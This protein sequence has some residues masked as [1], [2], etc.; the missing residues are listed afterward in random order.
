VLEVDAR[1]K[2]ISLGLK[3]LEPDPGCSS[4][5]KYHPGDK[6]AGKVRSLTDYGVFVGNRGG[7]R[8]HGCTRAISRG[9][10]ASTTRRTSTIRVTTSRRSSSRINH[11]EKKVS[12]GIKQL[13]GRSLGQH[14]HRVPARPR[15]RRCHRDLDRRVRPLRSHPR[16]RRRAHRD[17]GHPRGRGQQD[18]ARRQG[19]SA[20]CLRSIPSTVACSSR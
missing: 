18:Q 19:E 3:Q 4:P 10:F 11:D 15:H 8:R 1:A 2:R 5:N 7:G 16:G 12:L 6:I 17:A 20:R 14:A 13:W 9:P